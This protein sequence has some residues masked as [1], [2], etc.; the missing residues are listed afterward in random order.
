MART[1][2]RLLVERR[3]RAAI[4]L[5]RKL[6]RDESRERGSDPCAVDPRRAG[7]LEAAD[8]VTALQDQN[9]PVRENAVRLAE[10]RV[11]ASRIS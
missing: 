9:A 5:L 2:Q 6:A 10:A 11:G 4:P 3:D 1:A 7:G 8:I